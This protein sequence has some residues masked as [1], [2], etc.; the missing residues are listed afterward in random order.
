MNNIRKKIIKYNSGGGFFK[1]LKV[2][3]SNHEYYGF[4]GSVFY[5]YKR[6]INYFL[7]KVAIIFPHSTGRSFFHKLR[8]VQISDSAWIG[9]NVWIDEAFPNYVI[10]QDN[11]A[12]AI[13][14]RIFAHS[15]PPNY[16]KK[17]FSSYVDPVIIEENVWIGAF[18]TVLPGVKIGKGS[19]ISAGSV[20]VNDIP[21]NSVV[22]GNPG[23][24]ITK[25][26][27]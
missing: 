26:S 9:A 27:I 2:S 19:V 6:L 13:G 10:I 11:S 23:R 18:C 16:H 7:H 12:I 25:I 8:G 24:V 15:I 21:P 22:R 1:S 3:A 14:S 4:L 17:V 5:F 20:V